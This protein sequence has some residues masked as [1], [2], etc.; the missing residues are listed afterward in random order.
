MTKAPVKRREVRVRLILYWALCARTLYKIDVGNFV[1]SPPS[2]TKSN[3]GVNIN[4]LLGGFK[5]ENVAHLPVLAE[6]GTYVLPTAIST[7]ST[8]ILR[9]SPSTYLFHCHFWDVL[10]HGVTPYPVVNPIVLHMQA[11]V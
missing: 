9:V 3:L 4:H 5:F 8:D 6:S 2:F 11:M 10:N 7:K 1:S